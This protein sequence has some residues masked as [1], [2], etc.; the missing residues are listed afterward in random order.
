[1]KSVVLTHH[2]GCTG[3]GRDH[4]CRYPVHPSGGPVDAG[5]MCLPCLLR[6]GRA[7]IERFRLPERPEYTVERLVPLP[8]PAASRVQ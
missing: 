4:F 1:M 7:V 3:A 2:Q 8:M 6:T 5:C